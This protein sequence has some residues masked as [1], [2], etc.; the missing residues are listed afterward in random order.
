VNIM[1]VKELIE[2]LQQMDQDAPVEIAIH[3]YNKI[4]PVAYMKPTEVNSRNGVDVR[5]HASLPDNMR[6]STLKQAA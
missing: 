3:Q 2:K 6:T 4:Y 1:T 5:V